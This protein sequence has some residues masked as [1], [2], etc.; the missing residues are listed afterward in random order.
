MY[1]RFGNPLDT[2]SVKVHKLY[3]MN[4]L[5]VVNVQVGEQGSS[6]SRT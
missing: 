6:L 3:V 5:D 2:V 1:M 4:F